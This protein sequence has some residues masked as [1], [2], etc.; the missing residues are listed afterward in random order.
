MLRLALVRAS[1]VRASEA[2]AS[3]VRA[4][5]AP[6][7]EV[8]ASA[9]EPPASGPWTSALARLLGADSEAGRGVEGAPGRFTGDGT[10]NG[11]VRLPSV[12][13]AVPSGACSTVPA[14]DGRRAS[15]LSSSAARAAVVSC[16]VF[17]LHTAHSHKRAGSG[18]IRGVATHV[19]AYAAACS[20]RRRAS[21]VR[22][23]T[24]RRLTP[25]K[26]TMRRPCEEPLCKPPCNHACEAPCTA[27]LP[28]AS[29]AP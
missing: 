27:P 22:S 3:G 15:C 29:R 7:S 23:C 5:K 28:A 13:V 12:L 24:C 10:T 25:S 4:S 21:R 8:A 19:P 2:P 14:A 11:F 9:S 26:P 20:S 17:A 1:G 6:A 16:V 18:S